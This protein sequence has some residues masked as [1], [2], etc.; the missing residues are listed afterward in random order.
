MPHSLS[1][2]PLKPM[3]KFLDRPFGLGIEASRLRS[4]IAT[5]AS[6]DVTKVFW[7]EVV[8]SRWNTK[9]VNIFDYFS[10]KYESFFPGIR[11]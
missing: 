3:L 4:V 9:P 5:A 6:C 2:A 1:S 8:S 11:N 7:T 10:K